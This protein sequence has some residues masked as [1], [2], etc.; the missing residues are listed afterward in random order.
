MKFAFFGTDNFAVI[1]LNTLK[2][3]GLIP[4]LV[5]T[6]PDKPVGRKQIITPPPSKVWAIENN[7]PVIQP[8]S[9]KE[10]PAELKAGFDV[11]VTASYGKIIP[12]N[13]LDLPSHGSLN[14]HP[15]LLPKYRGPAPLEYTLL[16]G[17]TETGVTIMQMDAKMDEGPILAVAKIGLTGSE[18]YFDLRDNLAKLGANT[19]AN[20]L[21]DYIS[22][23][24]KP[25]AQD[26]TAATYTKFITKADGEV[27]PFND[28]TKAWH[29]YRAFID[30]PGVWFIKDG[31]RIVIKKAHFENNQFIVERVIPEGKT[32]TN[33]PI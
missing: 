25:T 28:Q 29:K 3:H 1:V 23:K 22:G 13:I 31:K 30:W 7:V 18:T 17:D 4:A 14:I 8:T 12:Q 16:N 27:D 2:E 15:S 26:Q 21:P 10:I 6:T 19:L 5:V 33:W 24:L 32:E 11:F 9:L 20:V